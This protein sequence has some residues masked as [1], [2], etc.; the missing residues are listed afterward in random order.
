MK[1]STE[2][3][4]AFIKLALNAKKARDL[5]ESVGLIAHPESNWKWALRQMRANNPEKLKNAPLMQS[6]KALRD[7]KESKLGLLKNNEI[8][9]F[10]SVQRK[11]PDKE[12]GYFKDQPFLVGDSHSVGKPLDALDA[13]NIGFSYLLYS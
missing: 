10:K 13:V 11:H 1:P 3:N 7:I 2:L 6:G 5:A 12:I 8:Q 9:K 4:T